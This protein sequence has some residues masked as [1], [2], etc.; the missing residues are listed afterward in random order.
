[1]VFSVIY[2]CKWKLLLGMVADPTHACGFRNLKQK[3]LIVLGGEGK[4]CL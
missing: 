2:I 3:I 4:G 1:M